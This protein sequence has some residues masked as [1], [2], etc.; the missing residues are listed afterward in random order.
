MSPENRQ[1]STR[2][3]DIRALP[4]LTSIVGIDPADRGVTA[5]G[6]VRGEGCLI[7]VGPH[8]K[9]ASILA[10]LVGKAAGIVTY[11]QNR[12]NY[13]ALDLQII[14][15]TSSGLPSSRKKALPE[16]LFRGEARS[17]TIPE[18]HRRKENDFGLDLFRLGDTWRAAVPDDSLTC[19]K[20]AHAS[21][22]PA[23]NQTD[24]G[25]SRMIDTRGE[26][27]TWIVHIGS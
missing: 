25:A 27:D 22:A 8:R 17:G 14:W 13:R 1:T 5:V 6:D 18:S 2:P 21:T 9:P 23:A 15:K 24:F 26:R 20:N 4:I 16:R 19:P 10:S 3:R 11:R 7:S 12:I